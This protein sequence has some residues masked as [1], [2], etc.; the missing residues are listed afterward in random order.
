MSLLRPL[1]RPH[2]SL[3]DLPS[4]WHAAQAASLHPRLFTTRSLHASLTQQPFKPRTAQLTPI[5][6]T[7]LRPFSSTSPSPS[8]TPSADATAS[9]ASP[10][11]PPFE[12][13]AAVRLAAR[14]AREADEDRV[15][16]AACGEVSSSEDEGPEMVDIRNPDT[17][18]IGGPRGKEPTRY[19][20]WE[21]KG[22]CWDF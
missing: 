17:G 2:R 18:E 8:P 5:P 15:L 16:K 4:F 6:L 19:G 14:Q 13:P 7:P 11:S 12:S 9:P 1:A 20:D 10:P 21:A 22:R 3:A